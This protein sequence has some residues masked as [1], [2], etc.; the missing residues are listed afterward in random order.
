MNF[1]ALAECSPVPPA[2]FSTKEGTGVE[3]PCSCI[4]RCA[5][6][7]AVK[8]ILPIPSNNKTNEQ[9]QKNVMDG[10]H[11]LSSPLL[12]SYVHSTLLRGLFLSLL[13]LLCLTLVRYARVAGRE[14]VRAESGSE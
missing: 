10:E 2:S 7:H 13:G 3:K 9:T 4:I 12:W 14:V 8:P 6:T 11:Y 5:R 1:S